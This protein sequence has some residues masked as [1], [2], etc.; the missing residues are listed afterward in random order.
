VASKIRSCLA[1]GTHLAHF[2]DSLKQV[3]DNQRQQQDIQRQHH[4][5]LEEFSTA[6]EV[7]TTALDKVNK[8]LVQQSSS[9]DQLQRGL[10]G[11]HVADEQYENRVGGKELKHVQETEN[12]DKSK[13]QNRYWEE[14]RRNERFNDE[15]EMPWRDQHDYMEDRRSKDI[16]ASRRFEEDFQYNE[17]QRR[18]RRYEEDSWDISYQS[19]P[20]RLDF[21]KFDGDNPTGWIYKVE[22]YFGHYQMVERQK[23]KMAA[24]HM[25]G[26]K[27]FWFQD[28]EECRYF[29]N[30][31]SFYR[32]I[33][34]AVWASI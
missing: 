27:L 28:S 23:L 21:P 18:G 11:K 14:R 2:A 22:Q 32:S 16:R 12:F 7:L 17:E 30:W 8:T 33:V 34:V 10:K 3:E 4:D 15:E 26:E 31:R 9:I 1:E 19:R 24:F 25:E 13:A 29:T 6:M 5:K 20:P